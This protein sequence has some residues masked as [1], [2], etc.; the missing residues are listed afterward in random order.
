MRRYLLVVAH[1]D[2]ELLG[3]GATMC[4]AV[5]NG[6]EV[7]V[8]TLS[9]DSATREDNLVSPMV[10]GYQSIGVKD[11]MI[12]NFKCIGFGNEDHQ[13]MVAFIETAIRKFRPTDVITHHPADVNYDHYMTSAVCQEAVRLPQR[14]IGYDEKIKRFSFMEVLSSTSFYLN[15]S[16]RPFMPNFYVSVSDSHLQKKI[17]ALSLYQAVLRPAPFPRCERTIKALAAVRG[18]ESGFEYA[19]AFQT[20]FCI[21]E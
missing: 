17:A 9:Q 18:S 13:A 15:P 10:S 4:K 12:G 16:W 19:E 20:V 3:A 6:D 2:D 14:Q 1:P 8:C 7:Y 5:E 21:E 11:Y